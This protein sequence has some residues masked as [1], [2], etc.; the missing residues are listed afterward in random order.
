PAENPS[1]DK[2]FFVHYAVPAISPVMRLPDAPPADGRPGG[3]V[4]IILAQDEY[5]P[6][7]FVIRAMQDH[8]RVELALSPLTR[9]DRAVFPADQVDLKVVKVWYQNGNAWFSYFAD[10]GLTL[11]PELLLHD[12]KLIRVD[13]E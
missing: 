13:T 2:T 12:E 3:E 9:E 5:E 4:R 7:S 10:V 11:V 1:A 6:G 8:D